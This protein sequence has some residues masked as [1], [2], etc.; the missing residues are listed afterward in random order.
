MDDQVAKRSR[1]LLESGYWCAE[2]VLL[3]VSEAKGIQSQLIPKIATGFCS[4]MA[5]TGGQCGALSGGIMSISLLLGRTTPGSPVNETYSR[6]ER[7]RQEFEA[8]FGSTCCSELLGLELGTEEGLQ[9]FHANN[10]REKCLAYTEETV[11]MVMALLEDTD[12][13]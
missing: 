6:V 4:G 9:K 8:R 12:L 3:T 1:E 13:G 11:R 7:L 2:S 5:R 10:L